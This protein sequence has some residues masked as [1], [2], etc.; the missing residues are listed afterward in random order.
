LLPKIRLKYSLLRKRPHMISA[1][2]RTCSESR[3]VCE[4]E[5]R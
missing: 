3:S 2:S 5:R 1:F 4:H